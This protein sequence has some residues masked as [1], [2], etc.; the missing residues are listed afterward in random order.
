MQLRLCSAALEQELQGEWQPDLSCWVWAEGTAALQAHISALNQLPQHTAAVT[1]PQPQ[2]GPQ[3]VP[4]G[5][6]GPSSGAAGLGSSVPALSVLGV[7]QVTEL[8]S[9]LVHATLC[10]ACT[11]RHVCWV[12]AGPICSRIVRLRRHRP[13]DCKTC[14]RPAEPLP[15]LHQV[16]PDRLPRCP[17]TLCALT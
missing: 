5:A 16:R 9:E 14:S 7:Q 2:P 8:A 3:T 4:D 15:P 10:E 12:P 13:A 11:A 6:P 17:A 1:V